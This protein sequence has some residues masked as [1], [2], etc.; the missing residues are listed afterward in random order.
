MDELDWAA[1]PKA[2]T[3]WDTDANV[4]CNKN[5]YWYKSGNVELFERINNRGWGDADRYIPRPVS[6]TVS[7]IPKGVYHL[8]N[9]RQDVPTPT[10]H[11]YHRQIIGLCGTAVQVDVYRVQQAF[12]TTNPALEHLTKKALC[13][14]TRGH[15]DTRQDILDII[16]SAQN[17]L[18]LHDQLEA[19]K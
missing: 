6:R 8:G 17:A 19:L 13:A 1:A 14:G 11:K 18:V 10:P 16:E 15:K 7:R 9:I 2:A 5:G 4:W 12:P 3:H